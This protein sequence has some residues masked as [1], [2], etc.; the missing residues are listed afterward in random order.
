MVWVVIYHHFNIQDT[1][2]NWYHLLQYQDNPKELKSSSH[3]H[4][5]VAD[6]KKLYQQLLEIWEMY[7]MDELLKDVHHC[8]RTSKCESMSKSITK[9]SS[10]ELSPLLYHCEE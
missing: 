7:C 4:C 5:K 8:W 9:L 6:H 2:G 10:H 3:Y 1:C